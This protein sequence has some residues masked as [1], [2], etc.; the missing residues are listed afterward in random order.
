MTNSALT[1]NYLGGIPGGYDNYLWAARVD[2]KI[3]PRQ[4]LSFA[5]TNGRRHAVPFTQGTANLPQPYL[6]A[7]LSTVVGDF[8]DVEYVFTLSPHMVNQIT[9]GYIYFG[10][11]PT[12]KQH[13]GHYAV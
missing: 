8:M 3:S 4:S 2:Y 7:T 13:R 11:P 6:A 10:G 5:A 12:Q 1:N 9:A